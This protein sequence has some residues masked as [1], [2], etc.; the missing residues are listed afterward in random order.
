[1]RKGKVKNKNWDL[2]K[3]VFKVFSFFLVCLY[4][5]LVY[6][7]VSDKIYGKNMTEFA[8]SRNTIKQTQ[9][10]TRGTIYDKNK[11]VLALNVSSYTL[12]AYLDEERSKNSSV[13][14]HVKDIEYTAE[15]LS[16]V[17][18]KDKEYFVEILEKGK[19]NNKKQVEFGTAGKGITE[20]V[21]EKIEELELPGISFIETKKR[22]YPNGN[23][24]SYIIGY[25]REKEINYKDEHGDRVTKNEITGELGIES[26]YNDLL[27][28]KDGYLEYQQDRYGYKISGTKEI[29]EKAEDGYNI[30]LTIDS[31]IQRFV[32]SAIT[33]ATEKYEPEL[34]MITVMD[35]K[36]GDIL[37]TTQ[38]PSFDPNI[39]DIKNYEN[40]LVSYTYEP[41]S[42]MKIYTYM[43]AIEN[44]VYNGT[45]TFKSGSYKI[46]DDKIKDWN[47]RGWG[48]ITYDKGFEYSSNVGIANILNN[49][50]TKNQLKDC[51]KKYGFGKITDVELTREQAGVINFNYK[52]EVA[53]AGFGQG[54][55]STAMQQLQALTILSNDGKMLKP[56]IV[57]KIVNPNTNEIYYESKKEETEPLAKQETVSKTKELMYNVV[58]GTDSWTTGKA[59]KIEGFDIIGKTGTAEIAENGRYLSD[60]YIYSFAGMYP[61]DNPEYIIYGMI[62]KPKGNTSKGLSDAVKDIINSISKYKATDAIKKEEKK[63]YKVESYINKNVDSVT[64][65]LEEKNITVLK[66]GDGDKIIKQYPSKN[67]KI[68]SKDKI[69]F[70]TNSDEIKM[71]DL[72]DYSRLEAKIILD[73]LEIKYKFEGY[74]Y[75]YEQSIKSGDKIDKDTEITL[76][77]KSRYIES[78]DGEEDENN[79]E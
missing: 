1:M 20:L 29:S 34:M 36:N 9:K 70:L 35:A 21:K 25:A 57:D 77:L 47:N 30:Y 12:F 40:A 38:T 73:L 69:I 32:E 11:E 39:R 46:G 7:S 13:P 52:I 10:A 59:Y 31:N 41:G 56:H 79:E 24:A 48:T 54:I 64:K 37:A 75:V 5:Q 72:T 27:N 6:L 51:L 33:E 68:T 74:G 67:T 61:K 23:F 19:K 18:G 14:L 22:Y 66:L 78:E 45:D 2:P 42:T 60:Q 8:A 15:K 16:E 53:T 55:S 17:L 49:G 3:V 76:K 26:Q 65:K 63:E 4:I 58:N 62:K 43:C 50:L 28:G 44:G 71:P